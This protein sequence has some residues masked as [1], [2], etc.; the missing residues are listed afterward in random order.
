MFAYHAVA[1][2]GSAAYP[3]TS[4]R[5]LAISISV[6]TSTVIAP[7]CEDRVGT[8]GFGELLQP[9]HD[10]APR[11]G[12]VACVVIAPE[13]CMAEADRAATVARLDVPADRRA[14]PV[15]R[16]RTP[17]AR[18][19][20]TDEAQIEGAGATAAQAQGAATCSDLAR[21]VR[22]LGCVARLQGGQH[23]FHRGVDVEPK[24]DVGHA[25]S[26]ISVIGET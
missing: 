2:S 11:V 26:F 22:T 9:H 20:S 17:R 21:V 24:Q 3:E 25:R 15:R 5:G 10:L 6:W 1:V 12:G 23:G 19:S 14:D 4:P 18:L 8:T 13:V 7:S 16:A